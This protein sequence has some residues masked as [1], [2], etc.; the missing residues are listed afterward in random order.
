MTTKSV[1]PLC[2]TIQQ[3][4]EGERAAA[5]RLLE[6]AEQVGWRG[7]PPVEGDGLREEDWLEYACRRDE[8]EQAR[9][10]RVR[11]DNRFFDAC[12]RCH[13]DLRAARRA[14]AVLAS[15][16]PGHGVFVEAE[17]PVRATGS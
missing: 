4:I 12:P 11:A 5:E 15:E 6:A 17:R 7:L 13:F 16:L 14:L 10:Q 1:C 2:S 9:A 8:H 3:T